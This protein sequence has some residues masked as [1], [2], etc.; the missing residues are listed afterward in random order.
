MSN[1]CLY[2]NYLPTYSAT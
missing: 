1:S 2:R